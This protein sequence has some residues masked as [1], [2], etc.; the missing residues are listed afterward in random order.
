MGANAFRTLFV[1]RNECTSGG[2]GEALEELLA[3][4]VEEVLFLGITLL[5]L[6][7]LSDGCIEAV[8]ELEELVAGDVS[9]LDGADALFDLGGD[10]VAEE[11]LLVVED[12]CGRCER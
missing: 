4:G 2:A 3:D 9:G 6:G 5:R 1:I 8:E 7:G 11:E 12:F 10:D